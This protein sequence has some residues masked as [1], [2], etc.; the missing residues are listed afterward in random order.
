[1]SFMQ[2]DP[3]NFKKMENIDKIM[4]G[5]D[6]FTSDIHVEEL[7]KEETKYIENL[8]EKLHRNEKLNYMTNMTLIHKVLIEM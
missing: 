1:M 7:I 5:I 3:E 4:L 8:K 2:P 6:T